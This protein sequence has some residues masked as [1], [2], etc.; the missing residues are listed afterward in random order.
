MP[1]LNIIIPV[2][3]ARD[4]LP[5]TLNSLMAQ[6]RH[7]FITTIVNDC[8]GIDYSDIIEKYRK[9]LSIKYIVREENG[10]PGLACQTGLDENYK[11]TPM[12]DYVMFVD[13]DDMLMPRAVDLLYTEAKKNFAD[14]VSGEILCEKE[15]QEAFV[16]H[17]DKYLTW[18]HAKIYRARYL[19]E[20]GL[21][22][23]PEPRVNEDS[24]FNLVAHLLTEKKYGIE[25]PLYLWRRN[26]SSITRSEED[27]HITHNF[28]Y[29]QAQVMGARRILKSEYRYK[30][31]PTFFNIYKAYELEF[32]F[33]KEELEKSN[34]LVNELFVMPETFKIFKDARF[35]YNLAEFCKQTEF[36]D[37]KLIFY[38]HSFNSWCGFFGL[39]IS[40]IK[41]S[42]VII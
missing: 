1:L 15:G 42:E 14:I 5:D 13:A 32:L 37:G 39:N 10:G 16:I 8:D 6:T 36:T 34:K 23:P 19:Q 22:F 24:Y 17:K 20:I 3:K 2:Y 38:P 40:D 29:L 25:E 35:I 27:F 9:F 28:E 31:G 4:T 41:E 18:R 33:H 26:L 12:C 11:S 7:N 21:R 30:L